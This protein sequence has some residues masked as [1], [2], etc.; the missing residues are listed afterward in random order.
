MPRSPRYTLTCAFSFAIIGHRGI[1]LR[2][3][4][5]AVIFRFCLHL[6]A[7]PWRRLFDY[8]MFTADAAAYF[9]L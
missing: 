3:M 7:E 8:A 9:M 4:P 6:R 2:F 1:T 5:A